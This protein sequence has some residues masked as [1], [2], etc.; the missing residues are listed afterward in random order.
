MRFHT[1]YRLKYPRLLLGC[2]CLAGLL[3]VLGVVIGREGD[4]GEMLL[5]L[6]GS[7][8][9]EITVLLHYRF[10]TRTGAL[11]LQAFTLLFGVVGLAGF[12][13]FGLLSWSALTGIDNLILMVSIVLVVLF[14]HGLFFQAV[15]VTRVGTEIAVEESNK[16]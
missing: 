5:M 16:P 6:L 8:V 2:L 11:V 3:Q 13:L 9:P 12:G 4:W 15:R 14:L 7:S 1:D 10:P